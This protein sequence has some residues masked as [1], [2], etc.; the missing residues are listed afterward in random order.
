M[1]SELE[2]TT[3]QID[4]LQPPQFEITPDDLSKVER[5]ANEINRELSILSPTVTPDDGEESYYDSIAILVRLL[6]ELNQVYF[7][8]AQRSG[9]DSNS[10]TDIFPV[11]LL[12]Q[13]MAG[14]IPSW[15]SP[16]LL[17]ASNLIDLI[18]DEKQEF[19][20]TESKF[21]QTLAAIGVTSGILANIVYLSNMNPE[22][23][24]LAVANIISNLLVIL[25]TTL[26]ILNNRKTKR[27]KFDREVEDP[28]EKVAII[29]PT[30]NEPLD[31][32]ENTLRSILEQEYKNGNMLLVIS[33]D[34]FGIGN[35][36]RN[37]EIKILMEN[38]R[39]E[40][41]DAQIIYNVPP[42]KG[43]LERDELGEAK[44]G[45]LNSA[46][47]LIPEGFNYIVTQDADDLMGDS[48]A[49]RVLIDQMK[50]NK[51]L[52]LI[53]SKKDI[54]NPGEDIF[55][56]MERVFY[57]YMMLARN[58]T[59]TAFSCGSGVVYR[60]DALEKAGNFASSNMV[61]DVT[62][63]IDIL[64]TGYDSRYL[65]I[66]GASAQI[67]PEDIP[68]YF[69]QRSTW[70][71][72]AF[73][74]LF[75][76]D[77]SKL[78][79]TQRLHMLE[80]PATY[81]TPILVF[82]AL[83]L[84]TAGTLLGKPLVGSQESGLLDIFYTLQFVGSYGFIFLNGA[85]NKISVSEQVKSLRL[86]NSMVFKQISSLT[87]ALINGPDNKPLYVPTRKETLE[88]NYL[89]M[90]IPNILAILVI[91]ALTVKTTFDGQKEVLEAL[92][93]SL[94]G[95]LFIYAHL[96]LIKASITNSKGK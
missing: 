13:T 42:P 44:A 58:S 51:N 75:Y 31:M 21:A 46:L 33:D 72:D 60:R 22:V 67:S 9:F 63:S 89:S 59:N 39:L 87:S 45:N 35:D 50:K 4:S 73:R 19:T 10:S 64:G 38:L 91:I 88:G 6:N 37:K 7:T 84:G 11:E 25:S 82:M 56:N 93:E 3:K 94:P 86:Y 41:P 17:Q 83:T 78:S 36:E 15:S 28:N 48:R 47:T 90:V 43:S 18:E 5:I 68:N 57:E 1:Q 62:T 80:M 30:W 76:K 52:G 92:K 65:E 81:L 32:V 74:T 66:L 12:E 79:I 27:Y 54:A 61:E 34:G 77:L 40:Y 24:P 8:I 20:I 69:K 16:E 96:Y 53:Q 70:M 71:L 14:M 26:F 55:N 23:T 95:F 49:L 29:I 85:A 2:L